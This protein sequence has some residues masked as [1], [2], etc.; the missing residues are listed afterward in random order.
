ML[1]M[2]R[3]WIMLRIRNLYFATNALHYK[4]RN[5][6]SGWLERHSLKSDIDAL[7]ALILEVPR[8]DGFPALSDSDALAGKLREWVRKRA[9]I[10]PDKTET[11]EG[12]LAE[13]RVLH[14]HA[15][16]LKP[17]F[18]ALASRRM[19]FAGQAYYN[20]WYLS[21][22][23]RDLDW[24]ADVLNWDLN[25]S[26]Q[27]YYHGEDFR[28]LPSEPYDTLHDL[29]F[30]MESIYRYDLFHFANAHGICF[31][32]GLQSFFATHVGIYGE[33][34]L[35]KALGKPIV[36]S[37]SGCQDGVTQTAFSQWGPESVCSICRWRDFPDICSD[38]RNREWAETRN[39]LADYQCNGGS[40]R[41]DYNLS[42]RVHET[43]EFFCLN[44]DIWDPSLP[45]PE[46]LLL[47]PESSGSLRLYHAVGNR[48]SRTDEHG[49]NVKCTHIYLPLIE[50][51]RKE[52]MEL[53]L[54]EPSN[55]PNKDVRFIQMQADIFLD[56][57]T[58]GWFGANAREAMML[59]KVV[60]CYIRPEWLESVRTEMP[61]YAEEL[62]IVSALPDTVEAVL[63]DLIAHPEKRL[64]IGKK[65][66]AFAIKWHSDTA[67]A[68][69]FDHVYAEL[70]KGN[71]QLLEAYA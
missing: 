57:L 23:L 14:Q 51:L 69:R 36:Y 41:A 46:A 39:M 15:A 37:H 68:K 1:D 34:K 9:H 22:R 60:I 12:L 64:E 28:F 27:I 33:I 71:P 44:P 26:S 52:G 24:R 18:L 48:S 20:S 50:K 2:C 53:T 30:F 38:A 56:Q 11:L 45:I 3:R 66:R 42:P 6:K 47:P 5:V 55:V 63:R 7:E 61:E 59:G 49:V 31:G 40:N 70:I 58:Y 25:P 35:L 19:L 21:R 16:Q 17:L 8:Q 10:P 4:I 65:S 54:L 32:F 62:P 43:P 13:F 29:R 67:G